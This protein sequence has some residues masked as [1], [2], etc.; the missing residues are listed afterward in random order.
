VDEGWAEMRQSK[1]WPWHPPVLKTSG[2][3]I[4]QLNRYPMATLGPPKMPPIP[5]ELGVGLTNGHQPIEQIPN[6]CIRP[7]QNAPIPKMILYQ[8]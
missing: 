1:P 8:R 7:S 2:T 5:K 6:G 3:D 4:P